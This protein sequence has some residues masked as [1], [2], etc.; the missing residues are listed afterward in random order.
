MTDETK[1][2]SLNLIIYFVVNLLLL[3]LQSSLWP[4][5]AGSIPSPHFLMYSLLFFALFHDLKTGAA[6]LI[7][8]VALYSSYSIVPIEILFFCL[9][10]IYVLVNQVKKRVFW[11]GSSYFTLMSGI[12]VILF[13][14]CYYLFSWMIEDDASGYASIQWG[15]WLL[16]LLS[17]A[18]FAPLFY[19]IF[20]R[21]EAA[22]RGFDTSDVEEA[23]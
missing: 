15:F 23:I 12:S 18:L 21:V 3:G 16:Q 14:F 17:T 10:C 6:F 11:P 19:W 20:V 7:F 22:T 9:A 8:S 1:N 4:S 13:H 5:I 2:E